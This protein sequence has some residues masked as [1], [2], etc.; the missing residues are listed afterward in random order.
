MELLVSHIWWCPIECHDNA[1]KISKWGQRCFGHGL[2]KASLIRVDL[3]LAGIGIFGDMIGNQGL[4]ERVRTQVS[5]S[6]GCKVVE[7]HGVNRK[8][9]SNLMS[10]H[11]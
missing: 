8:I 4:C 10:P 1:I 11:G 7:A 6:P 2:R 5:L 9:N 3:G